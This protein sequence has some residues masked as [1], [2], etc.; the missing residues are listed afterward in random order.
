MQKMN[1]NNRII[2]SDSA[3]ISDSLSANKRFPPSH[4]EE[5]FPIIERDVF[6]VE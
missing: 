1:Q 4:N 5:N 2:T 3:E 6:E